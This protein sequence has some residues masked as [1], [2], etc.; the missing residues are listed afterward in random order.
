MNRT[1]I[2]FGIDLGTT[3]SAVAVFTGNHG[4]SAKIIKNT[5][6]GNDA[7]ITPSAVYIDK[8]GALRVGLR[9]KSRIPNK[10]TGDD[11]HIEFKRQ[12]GTDHIYSFKSSG[13]K[14]RPEEL[15]AEVLKSL[16]ADVQQRTGE[17]VE[18][19]VI[20]VPAA[21]ELHQCDATKKAAQLAGFKECPLLLEPTAAA[22]AYGF[23]P[24]EE[25]AYWLVYD[26]GGGTFDAT[27][28]KSE[29]GTIHV[30]N[31]G[32]DNFLGGSNIDWAIV[33]KVVA[34]QVMKSLGLRNFTRS[35]EKWRW[36]FLILKHV[37]EI[38]KIEL[39][40]TERA[41]L[42]CKLEDEDGEEA[43]FE[44]ELT[45]DE[46]V[47]VAEPIILRSIEISKRVLKEQKLGKE[48][49]KKVILVG[50]P[51]LAL[52]F[53]EILEAKLGIPLDHSADPLTVVARGAA[54]FAG[55]QRFKIR[56][57]APAAVGEYQL[58]LAEA[59][60]PVGLESAPL[61]GGKVSGASAQDF[62]G[63]TLE[64]ANSKTQ[65]RSGKVSLRPDGVFV[66]NLH[67]EKGE[68]NTFNIELC[69][70]SGR[71]QK[72]TPDSLTYTIMV[73]GDVEQPLINSMGIALANNEYDKLFEKGRGLPLKAT[74]DYRTIHP[75]RQGR[76]EDVF[77]IP[78]VEGEIE[79][80]DR[81][82]LNGALEIRGDMVRRDLPAGSE[83]EVTLKMDES[84]ILTVVAYV[85]LLDEE[86]AAKIEMK[87]HQP[88]P[89]QLTKD[90]EAEMKRFREV[91]SKA[92][93][94]GGETAERLVEEV[95]A[96]PLAQDVKETLA[97]AKAD[98][99]AALQ[100]EKRLLEL[101]LKLD[102]A[103]DALEWP[104]L[105]AE[106]RNWLGYLQK[107]ADQPGNS[108]QKQ[109]AD[110]FAA[111]VEEIIRDKKP[112]R[113]RKKI[114]QIAR[115]YH[116]IVMAQF[117]WWVYQFQKMDEQ[118]DAMSDPAKASKLLGQGRDCL[119]KNNFT[120]LQN[121]VRQLWDLL[122]DET[123]EEAKRGYGSII[124]RR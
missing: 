38:A 112:D 103:A 69:D 76:A 91:K 59:F 89:D 49:I 35:N 20:T 41:T 48:A 122:P 6:D 8:K 55:T 75:I 73:G 24:D 16:R 105:V 109:K 82:R 17:I 118:Q 92:A 37:A 26:F 96:S 11:V 72:I 45:R 79:K 77:R 58:E 42:E 61:V 9:A 90:Y 7:D 19:S 14:R 117:G 3:N 47:N 29:E 32:G 94:T 62:T 39:S 65:W 74:R 44:C 43:E 87:R 21:F 107:V 116:E 84:R 63:F 114:E 99:T 85:P 12:M 97:A 102:E 23:K 93:A 5:M 54:V 110:D 22:L 2:D 71:K 64:L 60:K 52:Y 40:R 86:F 98:P 121:V 113:L 33:E 111:E 124:M 57:A 108:Q 27:I 120:G 36:A 106:S 53:R 104:A 115:L 31:S 10:N 25:K 51:T 56:A 123:V 101:K 78:V 83:V 13:E 68:R 95:E 119:A 4:E 88:N 80:A 70:A 81:N 46:V 15:S 1:T 100:G 30:A 18:A 67:A 66:A 50:G 28:I 34:P